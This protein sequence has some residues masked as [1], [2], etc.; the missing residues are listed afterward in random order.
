MT[1]EDQVGPVRS[2]ERAL[3]I[4]ILITHSNEPL[5]LS[6]INRGTKIPKA[7]ALRLLCTLEAFKL[8]QQDPVTRRY[9]TGPRFWQLANNSRND[10]RTISQPH[11]EALRRVTKETVSLV[12]PRNLERVVVETLATPHELSVTPLIGSSVPIYAGASGKLIM[13]Y[14]PEEE[15][16]RIIELTQLKP[17]GASVALNRRTYLEILSSIREKGY[18]ISVGDVNPGIAA[19]AAPVFDSFG[20]FLAAVSL[21]SPEV[22]MSVDSLER[23]AP[24][25]VETAANISADLGFDMDLLEP[26]S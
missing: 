6:E 15:R 18:A 24:S 5:G 4:L 9:E 11:L 23:V 13:T 26:G 8:I 3:N 2:V 10:L 19:I 1:G 12:C 17:V 22:R 14:L 16:N 20:K 7:T 21:H 25:V